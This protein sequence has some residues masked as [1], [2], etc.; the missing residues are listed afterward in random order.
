RRACLKISLVPANHPIRKFFAAILDARVAANNLKLR[1]KFEVIDL[2][3]APDQESV[4]LQFLGVSGL[5]VDRAIFDASVFGIAIPT[6]KILAVEDRFKFPLL[7]GD[8][9]GQQKREGQSR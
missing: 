5:P 9:F 7:R 3:I 6:R 4:V 1:A 8:E 2:S